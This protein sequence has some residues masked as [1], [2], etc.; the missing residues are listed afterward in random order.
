MEVMAAPR[1]MVVLKLRVPGMCTPELVARW[2]GS[3]EEVTRFRRVR[4]L[5]KFEHDTRFRSP[6]TA[7]YVAERRRSAYPWV[8]AV[9][10][11][12]TLSS[13]AHGPPRELDLSG[14]W[15]DP[16]DEREPEER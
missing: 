13:A 4:K 6:E 11:R 2:A 10:Y 12:G 14:G 5:S 3:T 9:L 15:T 8:S 7:I 16:I 1:D